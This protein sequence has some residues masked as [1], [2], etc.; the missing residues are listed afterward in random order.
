MDENVA[1]VH[2][3]LDTEGYKCTLT[4]CNTCFSTA[5][6]VVQTCLIVTL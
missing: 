5:A 1:H 2:C 6:M 4:V 3:M